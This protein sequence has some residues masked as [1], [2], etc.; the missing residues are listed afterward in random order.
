MPVNEKNERK[1]TEAEVLKYLESI[2]DAEDMFPQRT[3]QGAPLSGLLR[4]VIDLIKLKNEELDA[5]YF[6]LDDLLEV[7]QRRNAKIERLE[8]QKKALSKKR[9]NIF[10]R[11]EIYEK[12]RSK[13]VKE[14]AESAKAKALADGC[15]VIGVRTINQ[16]A[17]EMG[18]EL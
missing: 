9:V 8:I 14:F 6:T 18:V 2:I 17:K 7:I 10:E 5:L 11:T 3:F 12:A 4:E 16:I 13:A 1:L 15:R